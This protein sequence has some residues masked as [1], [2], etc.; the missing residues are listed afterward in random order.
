LRCVALAKLSSFPPIR[1]PPHSHLVVRSGPALPLLLVH[2]S[3]CRHRQVLLQFVLIVLYLSPCAFLNCSLSIDCLRC[4]WW[5]SAISMRSSRVLMRER[6]ASRRRCARVD[7]DRERGRRVVCFVCVRARWGE[8]VCVLGSFVRRGWAGERHLIA[9]VPA[10][11]VRC[12][13]ALTSLTTNSSSSS[14]VCLR[15]PSVLSGA[16]ARTPTTQTN[17]R[18]D[19][20]TTQPRLLK[21]LW[22][23]TC[24]R[25][26][27][28]ARRALHYCVGSLLGVPLLVA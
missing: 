27:T 22:R 17:Q 28:L 2:R 18:H 21:R 8:C 20:T 12:V 3:R 1:P 5:S 14:C 16:R 24:G 11:P 15:A 10:Y 7:T 6:G 26:T 9:C 13:D 23:R 4:R 25:T 19:D